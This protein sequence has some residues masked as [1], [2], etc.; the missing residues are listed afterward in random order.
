VLALSSLAST[1]YLLHRLPPGETGIAPLDAWLTAASSE[2]P[3][4][5]G[6][7]AI[8]DGFGFGPRGQA[9]R[10]RASSFSLSLHRSPLEMWLP[11]LN[12]GLGVLVLLMRLLSFKAQD[13]MD[14]WLGRMGLGNLPLVVYLVILVAKVVMASVDPERELEVLKYDHKGA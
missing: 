13:E 9:R 8:D 10:R 2:S 4:V 12:L 6:G 3:A 7:S 1:A 5:S 14:G 11:Y